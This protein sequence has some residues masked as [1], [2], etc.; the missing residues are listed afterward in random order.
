LK[1]D[2]SC[3]ISVAGVMGE[4]ER[5]RVV[6]GHGAVGARGQLGG[7][8]EV[9]PQPELG[10]LAE[11]VAGPEDLLVGLDEL[12]LLP[13]L[14]RDGV[15]LLLHGPA[16]EPV[17]HA[18]REVVAAARRLL[19]GEARAL[20]G[21]VG[22][23]RH[24]DRHHLVGLLQ[25]GVFERVRLVGRLLQVALGEGAGV[26]DQHAA[27]AQVGQVGLERGRVH[28][29]QHVRRVARG[30]D[31]LRPEVHLVAGHAGQRAGRGPDLGRVVGEG[32]EIGARER[33]R[34]GEL[35][36]GELHTVAGVADE[37]DGD[38]LDLL[39]WLGHVALRLLEGE[40]E[41]SKPRYKK[42]PPVCRI[43]DPKSTEPPIATQRNDR[44]ILDLT[45]PVSRCGRDSPAQCGISSQ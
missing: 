25:G 44:L 15:E 9:A 10:G 17:H 3:R 7:R 4:A 13:E 8:H 31:L 27:V 42:G 24:V 30:V 5:H 39:D 12:R 22:Q 11:G 37:P 19:G 38:G 26:D 6:A 40:P 21:G 43:A 36:A 2:I 41:C 23:L 1:Y 18:E 28:G 34:L 16:V 14:H 32:G 35:G 29:H 45:R 33:V 20:Q